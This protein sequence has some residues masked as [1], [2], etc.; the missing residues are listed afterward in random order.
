MLLE[1]HLYLQEKHEHFQIAVVATANQ[2]RK[3]LVMKLLETPGLQLDQMLVL[4]LQ[5]NWMRLGD[6]MELTE[7][8]YQLTRCTKVEAY[9][10][11]QHDGYVRRMTQRNHFQ[12][13]HTENLEYVFSMEAT[14]TEVLD[15]CNR[16]TEE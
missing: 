4:Y 16:V 5:N 3:L 10:G 1:G 7:L 9:E 11:I 13:L 8:V 15:L 12:H 14:G 6:P 2:D